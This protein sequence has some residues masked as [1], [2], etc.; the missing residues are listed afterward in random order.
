[1]PSAASMVSR[2]PWVSVVGSCA[3]KMLS[4]E[5]PH[6]FSEDQVALS[7]L[8]TLH[9]HQHPPRTMEWMGSLCFAFEVVPLSLCHPNLS[10]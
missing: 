7:P 2:G 5:H 3:E 1:M 9:F 8:E 6:L 4:Q 10:P